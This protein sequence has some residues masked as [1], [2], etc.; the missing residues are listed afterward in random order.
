MVE[1]ILF[2]VEEGPEYV[3]ENLGHFGGFFS[4]RE[5]IVESAGLN[6]SWRPANRPEIEGFDDFLWL[7]SFLLQILNNSASLNS[8][9]YGITIEQ[10]Q[11]LREIGLHFNF[12]GTNRLTSSTTEGCEEVSRGVSIGNVNS[13]RSE[14]KSAELIRRVGDLSKGIE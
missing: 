5:S 10:V 13:S 6:I 1:K 9:I 4:F 11:S 7:L 12:A 8:V 14:G 2:R 3:L